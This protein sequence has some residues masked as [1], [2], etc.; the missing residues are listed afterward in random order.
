MTKYNTFEHHLLNTLARR[1]SPTN[2]MPK[3]ITNIQCSRSPQVSEF[4]NGIAIE[5]SQEQDE[6][7]PYTSFTRNMH[8][9]SSS[10]ISSMSTTSTTASESTPPSTISEPIS[11]PPSHQGEED[12]EQIEEQTEYYKTC[13][14]HMYNRIVNSRKRASTKKNRSSLPQRTE[15]DQMNYVSTSDYCCSSPNSSRKRSC[16]FCEFLSKNQIADDEIFQFEM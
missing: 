8:S 11:F 3:T 2:S 15:Q 5:R 16:E 12:T 14:W 1:S 9:C 4:G 10:S 7:M 13:T 6:S